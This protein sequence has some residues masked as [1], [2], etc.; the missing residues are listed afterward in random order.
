MAC[1]SCQEHWFWKKLVVASDAWISLPFYRLFAGLSGGL[2]SE[3]PPKA[4]S[5]SR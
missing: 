1:Q 4:L 5:R 2:H 3:N